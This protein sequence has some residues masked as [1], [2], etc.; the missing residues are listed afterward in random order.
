[1]TAALLETEAAVLAD[2]RAKQKA[3]QVKQ[4]RMNQLGQ[5]M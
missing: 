1:V 5:I 3:W 2:R 4:T